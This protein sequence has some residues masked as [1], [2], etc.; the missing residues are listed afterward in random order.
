MTS[1]EKGFVR[2]LQ[3]YLAKTGGLESYTQG[4]K[5][6]SFHKGKKKLDLEIGEV[7]P[8]YDLASLTKVIFTVS[9]LVNLTDLKRAQVNNFVSDNLNWW[10][11]KKTK[12]KDFLTHSAGL[13]A[14]APIYE[15]IKMISNP[16]DRRE[17]LKMI[18]AG[19]KTNRK[20]KAIYSDLDFLML[21]FLIEKLSAS[22][23]LQAWQNLPISNQLRSL[24]FNVNN[25]PIFKRA[26]YAPTVTRGFLVKLRM[27]LSFVSNGAKV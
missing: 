1:A 3:S 4:L 26:Q 17:K 21:G 2:T 8:Y 6:Q 23:L 13:P 5:I 16:V 25:R 12:N 10:R 27:Y 20:Q 7:Y 19:Q 18:L 15:K 14:W 9:S 22:N 11:D 24:H